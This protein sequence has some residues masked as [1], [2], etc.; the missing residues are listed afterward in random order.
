[1][2]KLCWASM[3]VGIKNSEVKGRLPDTFGAKRFPIPYRHPMDLSRKSNGKSESRFELAVTRQPR[4][5][6]NVEASFGEGLFF[7]WCFPGEDET[8]GSC[9]SMVDSESNTGQGS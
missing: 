1:M 2:R 5:A 4:S 8:A 7:H 6:E 9:S 3:Q